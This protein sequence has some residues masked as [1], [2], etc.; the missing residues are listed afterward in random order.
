MVVICS[1]NRVFSQEVP[2]VKDTTLMYRNIENYSKKTKFA[3]FVHKLIFKPV[4]K[5][6]IKKNSFHKSKKINL[7]AFEGKII[8]DIIIITTDPFGYSEFDTLQKPE[9]WSHKTGNT[10][11]IKTKNSTIKNLLLIKVGKPF[12]S[13]LLKESERILRRQHYIRTVSI[14]TQFVSE[15]SDSVNVYLRVI[16][17]WNLI[18]DFASSSSRLKIA[19][20]DRNFFGLGH[21]FYTSYS[22]H[23]NEN[24]AH[25]ISYTIPNIKNTFIKTQIS[26]DID[27]EGNYAKFISIERPF[28]SV[29]TRWASGIYMDQQL[30]NTITFDSFENKQVNQF[31]YNS[32]DYWVGH[33]F[34]IFKGTS[35]FNRGTNFIST[36][37]FYN[38][39]FI[40]KPVTI[41]DSLGV[42]TNEKLYLVGIGISSRKYIQDKFIFNFN[43]IE[44]VATGFVYSITTGYQKKNFDMNF[45]AGAKIGLGNYFNFGY[46]SGSIEYGAYYK[47]GIAFQSATNLKLVYFTNLLETKSWKFRQFIKPQLI[48][49]NNR[50]E[51]NTDLL[52]LNEANGIQGFNSEFLYG[53]KKLLVTYQL[54][55]YS[56]WRVI[57]FRFNPFL[58]YSMGMLGQKN[59]G[60]SKSKVYS[61]VGIGVIISNDY[62]VFNS[63]QFSFSYYPTIPIDMDGNF[64]ANAFNTS[65]FNLQEF[66]IAKPVLVIYK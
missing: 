32:Q 49:G 26:Y 2:T 38:K 44:Y 6:K 28:Y 9:K 58:S 25:S 1:C 34:Q 63:F 55:G 8:N 65:D 27:L 46:L 4:A 19:L 62:M 48:I 33:A 50:I 23:K 30:R 12:D 22:N 20:K 36:A 18:P 52:T 24:S 31:K 56:P 66:E 17:T 21:E 64:K 42:Y 60:F 61:Q 51:S 7:A 15:A 47:D 57:G 13:L 40:E 39:S 11:H 43:I 16:D 5:Q 14:S 3:T 10:L 35:E 54:Q 45:Y 53:S 37:R 59:I 41:Q 29:I